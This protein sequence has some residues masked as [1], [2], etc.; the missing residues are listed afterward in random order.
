MKENGVDKQWLV[1]V[2]VGATLAERKFMIRVVPERVDG[3]SVGEEFNS[4]KTSI[5]RGWKQNLKRAM[6]LQV[7]ATLRHIYSH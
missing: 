7:I 4:K 3:T 2:A 1:T 5:N 6:A